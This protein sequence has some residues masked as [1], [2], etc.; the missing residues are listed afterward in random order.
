MTKKNNTG[1]SPYW[2]DY[3]LNECDI[4]GNQPPPITER[5]LKSISL[6]SGVGGID[7]ACE[8]CNIET[9]AFCEM[10]YYC[11]KLLKKRFY[12]SYVVG[13]DEKI[14]DGI[15]IFP[16]VTK[17]EAQKGQT[18]EVIL[19]YDGKA[20][21][22]FKEVQA[23]HGGFPCQPYSG[24][25]QRLGNSD[26]RA[27]FGE[28]IRLLDT[29]RPR[30]FLG[31]N[32]AHFKKL[33]LDG[34]LT[35]LERVGYDTWSCTL[36]ANGRNAPTSRARIFI[37]G[38][39]REYTAVHDKR[40]TFG[41][42]AE[43]ADENG[44]AGQADSGRG[45]DWQGSGGEE[46][47]QSSNGGR[48]ETLADE[49]QTT[50]LAEH[51][52]KNICPLPDGEGRGNVRSTRQLEEWAWTPVDVRSYN[53]QDICEPKIRRVCNGYGTDILASE[54]NQIRAAGNAVNPIQAYPIIRY[55]RYVDD[56]LLSGEYDFELHEHIQEKAKQIIAGMTDEQWKELRTKFWAKWNDNR[57]EPSEREKLYHAD[58]KYQPYKMY[59]NVTCNEKNCR[60]TN[61]KIRGK[62]AGPMCNKPM[63]GKERWV[64]TTFYNLFKTNIT[65]MKIVLK[66]SK[67]LYSKKQPL[68]EEI[69][70]Q[71]LDGEML[72]DE[73]KLGQIL[74]EAGPIQ[75][76]TCFFAAE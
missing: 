47:L 54:R 19:Y 29:I 23:V 20:E 75:H 25:G 11:Q 66:D 42:D 30:W 49:I 17:L 44:N 52:R 2:R 27:L 24:A 67:A 9:V 68:I 53:G 22:Q 71:M 56:M 40:T 10:D 39:D 69:W 31:E 15:P 58:Q 26:V 38:F 13:E 59:A 62:G 12:N 65:F 60:E 36:P 5:K 73:N 28:I 50:G 37:I 43:K 1:L 46:Q 51:Q 18:G 35:S 45:F 3:Y 4:A 21:T 70:R 72:C 6:F 8:L 7:I 48:T 74:M 33:G 61:A 34:I 76:D 55:L 64:E 16:D 57:F 32:V 14:K 63:D 41:G